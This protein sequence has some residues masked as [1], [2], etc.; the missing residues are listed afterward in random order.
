MRPL[1]F[2][3]VD[4][5]VAMEEGAALTV[6]AGQANR[7]SVLEQRRVGEIFRESPIH[8]PLAPGHLVARVDDA[9][10]A[11]VHLVLGRNLGHLVTQ[12]FDERDGERRVGGVLPGSAEIGTP[13][14]QVVDAGLFEQRP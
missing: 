8:G 1:L 11:A 7:E 12:F 10:D 5:R 14:G 9:L 6:L 2:L 4:H 3:V 13:V